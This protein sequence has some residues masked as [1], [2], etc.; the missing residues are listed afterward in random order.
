MMRQLGRAGIAE[1]VERNCRVARNMAERLAAEPG[2]SLVCQ[3]VLNQF[4]V[5]FEGSD[6]ADGDALTLE[7]V[8]QVQAD[9]IAFIGASQ[10]R[11]QWVMRASVCSWATTDADGDLAA[12]AVIAAWR[13]VQ[14]R[15]A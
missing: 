9:A 15:K 2:I 6:A 11:G 5:R 14:A 3:V 12:T 1:M 8:R 4:M 13:R 7:A 10:W